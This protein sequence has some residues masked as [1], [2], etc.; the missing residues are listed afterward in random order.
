MAQ[1]YLWPEK[2]SSSFVCDSEPGRCVYVCMHACKYVWLYVCDSKSGMHTLAHPICIY[3]C[4][5]VCICVCMHA[6]FF[7]ASAERHEFLSMHLYAYMHM[8]SYEYLIC[9]PV[10]PI[11]TIIWRQAWISF[12]ACICIYA[13]VFIWVLNL[14]TCSS[15]HY[16]YLETSMDF[17]PCK[18]MKTYLGCKDMWMS[19]ECVYTKTCM[20]QECV[21]GRQAWISLRARTRRLILAAKTGAC[22]KS[23]CTPRHACLENVCV[24][25]MHAF[26]SMDLSL[27]ANF[28]E[29][30]MS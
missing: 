16:N 24:E 21:C 7:Q 5:Y 11:I 25:D 26:P 27:A 29:R 12:H 3:V 23:V 10:L 2:F 20:L 17:P 18:N 13:C 22:Q 8:C 9:R 14:L 1:T 4:A 19:E 15:N 6:W 30:W 28:W